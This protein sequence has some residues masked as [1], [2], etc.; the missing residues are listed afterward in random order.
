MAFDVG[1]FLDVVNTFKRYLRVLMIRFVSTAPL[2]LGDVGVR[3]VSVFVDR[4]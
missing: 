1:C 4:S 2:L 3:T